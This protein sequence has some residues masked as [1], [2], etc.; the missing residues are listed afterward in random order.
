MK[1]TLTWFILSAFILS[2]PGLNSCKSKS[3]K[4]EQKKIELQQVTTIKEE[5]REN[6]YPLPN[7]ADVIN[8]L[9]D[10]GVTYI[11][12]ISNPVENVKKY[13]TSAKK[14]LNLGAYGANLSYATLYDNQQDVINY[15]GA[16]RTLANELNLAKVYDESLY[17]KIKVNADKRDTLVSILTETFN[18]TYGTLSQ[19]GQEVL[20]LLIVG[21]AWVEGMHL[22]TNVSGAAYNIAAISKVLLEQKKSFDT[23]LDITKN[24]LDDPN[25]SDFI[26]QLEPM[27]QVY[28]GLS[29]SLTQ[30]NIN[31]IAKAIEGIRKQMVE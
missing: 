12:G 27:K 11:N 10:Y 24:Y 28:A 13:F 14:A 3:D 16:I 25:L 21:G 26:K 22:T 19:N 1:R 15:L 18:N 9:S 7:S 8:M 2:L 4:S 30:T 23:Y 20:G 17:E 6:V 29:T 31:D 5:I